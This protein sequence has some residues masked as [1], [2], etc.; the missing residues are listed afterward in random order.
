MSEFIPARRRGFFGKARL[1]AGKGEEAH[2]ILKRALADEI[3]KLPYVD[4]KHREA[5]APYL[6]VSGAR[7]ADL[8]AGRLHRFTC[9]SLVNMLAYAGYETRVVV[10][11]VDVRV[12]GKRRARWKR[13]RTVARHDPLFAREVSPEVPALIPGAD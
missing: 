10:C 3:L 7:V 9:D 11:P 8:R 1:K 13:V 5:A 2:S 12:I 4:G 6:G